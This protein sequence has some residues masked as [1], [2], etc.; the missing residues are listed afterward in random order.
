MFVS[1]CANTKKTTSI[2]Q[3]VVKHNRKA[4]P[5]YQMVQ[6]PQT[7]HKIEFVGESMTKDEIQEIMG[8]P[9]K[10]SDMCCNKN[11]PKIWS[12]QGIKCFEKEIRPEAQ[13]RFTGNCEVHFDKETNRVVGWDKK[14][15][16]VIVKQRQCVANCNLD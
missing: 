5:R 4:P 10:I 1:S 7:T 16:R 15:S 9:D 3:T 11:K 13:S 14:T 8:Q 2:N 6:I 12:Y